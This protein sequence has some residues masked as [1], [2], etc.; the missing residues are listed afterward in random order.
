MCRVGGG[1][2]FGIYNV[3]AVLAFLFALSPAASTWVGAVG[4]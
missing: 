3:S 1:I 4:G 2:L